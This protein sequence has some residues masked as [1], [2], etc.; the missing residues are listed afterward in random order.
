MEDWVE[1][2]LDRFRHFAEECDYLQGVQATVDINSG[3]TGFATQ[4]VPL[5][6][7]ENVIASHSIRP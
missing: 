3:W 4:Y 6:A 2:A 1:E 7:P 5:I